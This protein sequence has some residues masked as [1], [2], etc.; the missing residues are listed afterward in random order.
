[1]DGVTEQAIRTFVKAR[2]P[3][4]VPRLSRACLVEEMEV[5][6]GRAR[7]DLAVIGDRL[8]GIEIK[9]P[10][11]S[12]TRLPSQ[13]KAYSQCFDHVVLLVHESLVAK[14]RPL[15]PDW[16]GLIAGRQVEG[17]IRYRVER[18]PAANPSLDLEKLLSLLWREEIDALL[19]DFLGSKSRPSA[20]K[21]S[22]RAELLAQLEPPVLHQASL[23]K[24][25]ERTEWRG[26]PISTNRPEPGGHRQ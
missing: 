22:I 21:K 7:I 5:C 6:S 12:V 16:W 10:Q 4:L 2:I 8:I 23:R 19:S 17:R 15:I 14:A 9:G 18:R 20:T 3:R 26:V 13:A 24:L 11:D 1:M 25:R